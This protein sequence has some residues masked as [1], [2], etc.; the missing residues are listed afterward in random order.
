M[1]DHV[2]L[3]SENTKENVK[4]KRNFNSILDFMLGVIKRKMYL[5]NLIVMILIALNFKR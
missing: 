3:L 4:I 5:N 2:F 1:G